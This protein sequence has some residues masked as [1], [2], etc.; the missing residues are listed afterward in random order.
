[1]RIDAGGYVNA[2]TM[3]SR[4]GFDCVSA[5]CRMGVSAL[6]FVLVE[7]RRSRGGHDESVELGPQT[8]GSLARFPPSS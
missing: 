3:R 1:M 7:A 4:R 5:L 8:K 6:L 2:D